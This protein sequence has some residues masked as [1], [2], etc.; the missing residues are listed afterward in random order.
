MRWLGKI[1][2]M[3]RG[4]MSA[5]AGS[6]G[7]CVVV[8][9]ASD[10]LNFR[11]PQWRM[12]LEPLKDLSLA[13]TA[14]VTVVLIDHFVT[15]RKV[16][17]EVARNIEERMVDVMEMFIRGSKDA[18]LVRFHKRFNFS[19][20][21]E[22]LGPGDELL[23]LDTY[24]PLN[25]EFIDKIRP[26]LQRLAKIRMLIIDPRCANAESRAVE[27]FAAETFSQEVEVFA[28]RVSSILCDVVDHS[29]PAEGC[30]ILAYD[31][32]P[33]VPMYLVTHY[34][35]PVRGYSGYFLTKPSALFAHM[36][37]TPT[38][39]GMLES[40]HEY[41][42]QKWERHLQKRKGFPRPFNS[43]AKGIS[44]SRG[45]RQRKLRYVQSA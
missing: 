27:I 13:A 8:F 32:L 45:S 24:C 11:F 39:G 17:V 25:P 40:M 21:F 3:L 16:A 42:E 30:Q 15:I 4:E 28:K 41:F 5:I 22:D 20:L 33:C 7:F 14:A 12:V 2:K 34:G 37:W 18:G 19:Q 26:A 23:W 9:L 31:D 36:E 35:V 6:L 44:V 38:K 43:H 10:S 29:V 1:H